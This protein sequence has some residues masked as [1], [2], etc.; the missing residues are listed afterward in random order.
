MKPET[1]E[2]IRQMLAEKVIAARNSMVDTIARGFP[3]R[4][5]RIAEFQKIYAI[6]DDFLEWLSEQENP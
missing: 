4:D 3:F 2:L 1:V 6:E 5:E